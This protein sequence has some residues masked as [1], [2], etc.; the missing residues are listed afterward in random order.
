MVLYKIL[1]AEQ[2]P[3]IAAGLKYFI[4]EQEEF[5]I[6]GEVANKE[7]LFRQIKSP[8]PHLLIIAYNSL[9]DFELQ[10][11]IRIR[12]TAPGTHILAISSRLEKSDILQVS[13]AGVI[14]F[15]TKECSHNEIINAIRATA[16]GEKFYCGKIL[17][18][19]MEKKEL[20][21]GISGPEQLT[22]REIQ[23]IR[24]I[25]QG[26]STKEIA[27][28]LNLSMHTINA[29]RKSILQKTEARSPAELA[30]KA[31]RLGIIEI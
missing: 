8:S 16:Q 22:N 1:L 9:P 27:D 2:Q 7:E 26:L 24:C 30:V 18:L 21:V 5:S 31:I 17:D 6:C 15:L 19:L 10:D 12:H 4:E 28:T 13:E 29:Y 11:F 20:Q 14:G 23:I 25:T 3:L